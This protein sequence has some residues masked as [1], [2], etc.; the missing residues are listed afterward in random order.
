MI[1]NWSQMNT[2]VVY[3]AKKLPVKK[4]DELTRVPHLGSM[5]L[6]GAHYLLPDGRKL[7]PANSWRSRW[8]V[9]P[10]D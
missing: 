1:E 7:Y 5:Y 3:S 8:I 9:H 2:G 10:K 6:A 4:Y